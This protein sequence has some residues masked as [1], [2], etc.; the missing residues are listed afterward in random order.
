MI[1]YVLNSKDANLD[2]HLG[3]WNY[4]CFKCGLCFTEPKKIELRFGNLFFDK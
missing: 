2:I 3:N 1:I 4:M